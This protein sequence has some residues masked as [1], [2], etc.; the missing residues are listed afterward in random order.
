MEERN[1]Y[2]KEIFMCCVCVDLRG[3]AA[4]PYLHFRLRKLYNIA[5]KRIVDVVGRL[6]PQNHKFV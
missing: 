3:A 6:R 1:L 2:Q 4:G 5:D